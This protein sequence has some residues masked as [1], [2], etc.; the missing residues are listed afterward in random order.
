MNDWLIGLGCLAAF[1]AVAA[2]IDALTSPNKFK[3]KAVAKEA[4]E[5]FGATALVI[6]I[7]PTAIV[8]LLLFAFRNQ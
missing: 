1:V 5:V 2:T 3:P 8:L 7:I 4:A 6:F